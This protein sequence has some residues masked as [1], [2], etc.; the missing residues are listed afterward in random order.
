MRISNDFI[1]S[2]LSGPE[3]GVPENIHCPTPTP[4]EGLSAH[5]SLKTLAFTTPFPLGIP[6]NMVEV[7]MFYRS[8]QYN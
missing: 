5:F 6:M 7:W 3:C 1:D 4:T 8:A 2:D